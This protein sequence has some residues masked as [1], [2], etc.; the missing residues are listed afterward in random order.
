MEE[1]RRHPALRHI[2]LIDPDSIGAKLYSRPEG[3]DWT[4]VDLL[5]VDAR[6][7]LT[8]IEVELRLGDIYERLAMTS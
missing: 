6:I 3:G 1:Y 5:G 2:L 8:A 7:A 4:D